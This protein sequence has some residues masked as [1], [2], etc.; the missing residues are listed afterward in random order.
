MKMIQIDI[1]PA[2]NVKIDAQGFEDSSCSQA[3]EQIELL[4]NGQERKREEKPE[5]YNSAG[6]AVDNKLIF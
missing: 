1:S 2:G 5:Y 3:T 4:L 6:A